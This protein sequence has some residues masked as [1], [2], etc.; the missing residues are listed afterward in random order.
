[1][2]IVTYHGCFDIGHIFTIVKEVV[3]CFEE[4]ELHFMC[5]ELF[6]LLECFIHHH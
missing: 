1:M 4:E 6:E 5:V 2:Q 3:S